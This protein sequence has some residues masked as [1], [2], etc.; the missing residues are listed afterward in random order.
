[1]HATSFAADPPLSYMKPSTLDMLLALEGERQS[2]TPVWFTLDAGP[3]PVLLTEEEH[4]P[5]VLSFAERFL[6]LDMVVCHPGEDAHLE[7]AHLF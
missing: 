4:L 1:M 7:E 5:R 3:N 2:G 6:P